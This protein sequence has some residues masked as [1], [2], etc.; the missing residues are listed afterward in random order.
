[1]CRLWPAFPRSP[2][3]TIEWHLRYSILH[4]QGFSL[5]DTITLTPHWLLRGAASEDWTW[6]R[7]LLAPDYLY[8]D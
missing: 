8:G 2:R 5:G 3:R 6:T 4:Q 1:M 7:Q